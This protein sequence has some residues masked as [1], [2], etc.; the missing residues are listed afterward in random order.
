MKN[1]GKRNKK[2]LVKVTSGQLG[3]VQSINHSIV[4]FQEQVDIRDKQKDR[5][6]TEETTK[7]T[8]TD[9]NIAH[10]I[11]IEAAAPYT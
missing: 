8:K 7:T 3:L 6:Q 1:R 5:S 10:T 2:T 9:K 11:R 4:L